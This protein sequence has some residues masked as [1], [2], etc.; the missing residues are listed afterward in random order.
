MEL[1]KPGT[2]KSF[3]QPNALLTYTEYLLDYASKETKLV[4]SKLIEKEIESFAEGELKDKL[5]VKLD[6]LKKGIRDLYF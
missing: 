2:I 6:E 3:C 4:G 5:M 1:S